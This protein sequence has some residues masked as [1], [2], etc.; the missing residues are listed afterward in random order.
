VAVRV[1]VV[2]EVDLVEEV[3]DELAEEDPWGDPD[4]AAEF[5]GDP[6]GEGGEQI[7]G[8]EG[9]DPGAGGGR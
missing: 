2:E 3:E 6:V 7:V 8:D 5:A 4:L 1:V 9:V